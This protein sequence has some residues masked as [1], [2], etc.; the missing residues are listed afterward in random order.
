MRRSC[1]HPGFPARHVI[2]TAEAHDRALPLVPDSYSAGRGSVGTERDVV[3]TPLIS[4]LIPCFNAERFIGETLESVFQQTW[5][6]IEV[7]VVDDG[8]SDGSLR[9]IQ[10]FARPNLICIDQVNRGAAASRNL[11]FAAARGEFLQF[12]DADDLISPNKLERQVTR[13]QEAPGCVA[14]A[15]WA[16]FRV[17]PDEAVFTSEPVWRDLNPLSWILES[18]LRMMFPALWLIPRGVALAAG[19]WDEALSLT[20]DTEYFTRLLL[21]ARGV[22]FCPGARAYYR[23]GIQGSLSGRRSPSAWRSF[24]QSLATCEGLV[25]QR[26]DSPRAR[27][28]FALQWQTFAYAAYPYERELANR[29]AARAFDLDP[30]AR[31]DPGGGVS[32]RAVRRVLGWRV[33]RRLQVAAGRP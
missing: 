21:H 3:T 23:S 14:S 20:D 16:R 10:R 7:I 6:P 31:L 18:G 9:E 28:M 11:A 15:E 12:L 8:S 30:A 19:P 5:T 32:F 13:L 22:L 1:Q 25:L 27:R 24:E 4:V 2:N 26:E 33:A 17:S 29:A